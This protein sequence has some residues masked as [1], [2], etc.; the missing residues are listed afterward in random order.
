MTI[1]Q[2]ER[3]VASV[4][5]VSELKKAAYAKLIQELAGNVPDELYLVHTQPLIPPLYYGIPS[6]ALACERALIQAQEE[7][8]FFANQLKIPTSRCLLLTPYFIPRSEIQLQRQLV[9]RLKRPV[10]LMTLVNQGAWLYSLGRSSPIQ[11][12]VLIERY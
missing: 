12:N 10:R 4:L 8:L 6:V 1:I 11:R 3:Q 5:M 9:R 2:D 7:L